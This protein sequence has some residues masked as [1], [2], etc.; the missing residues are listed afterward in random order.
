MSQEQ[1]ARIDWRNPWVLIVCG[2]LLSFLI[3][4]FHLVVYV[5]A[6]VFAAQARA[7]PAFAV[8]T[9]LLAFPVVLFLIVLAG[10][11]PAAA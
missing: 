7:W 2:L 9:I 4:P 5:V 8:A 10:A 6:A 3:S 1:I 11:I